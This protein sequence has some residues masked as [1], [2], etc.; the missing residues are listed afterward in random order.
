M[1]KDLKNMEV[2]DVRIKPYFEIAQMIMQIT[3]PQWNKALA[4]KLLEYK[5]V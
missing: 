2:L 5:L 4:I 3:Y 1:S